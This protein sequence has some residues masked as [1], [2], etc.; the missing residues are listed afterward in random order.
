MGKE[1]VFTNLILDLRCA[2]HQ[3]SSSTERLILLCFAGSL[4][5]T[6]T[7]VHCMLVHLVPRG[8]QSLFSALWP[9]H[10]MVVCSSCAQ[11]PCVCVQHHIVVPV[12]ELGSHYVDPTCRQLGEAS[13]FALIAQSLVACRGEA[14]SPTQIMLQVSMAI[15]QHD[16]T[17]CSL[18][19][20]FTSCSVQAQARDCCV[21]TSSQECALVSC[22]CFPCPPATLSAPIIISPPS[23]SISP[24]W[25]V[26][27]KAEKLI[28]CFVCYNMRQL[29]TCN[30]CVTVCSG[31]NLPCSVHLCHSP[32]MKSIK[33]PPSLSPNCLHT[34]A[35]HSRTRKCQQ[36]SSIIVCASFTFAVHANLCTDKFYNCQLYCG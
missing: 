3:L 24:P 35:S 23:D 29:Y 4:P 6:C 34:L 36:C 18:Q 7:P 16:P 26:V 25:S 31:T 33:C 20:T 9:V 17:L 5:V 1:L 14:S 19:H 10:G 2:S 27:A 13:G 22:V 15:H 12:Y 30:M 8:E 11:H 28:T 32:V 21:S